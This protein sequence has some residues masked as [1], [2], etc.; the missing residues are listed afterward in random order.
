[1]VASLCLYGTT[2]PYNIDRPSR[3]WS[4]EVFQFDHCCYSIRGR[5]RRTRRLSGST[6]QEYF[7]LCRWPFGSC[8]APGDRLNDQLMTIRI[9]SLMILYARPLAFRRPCY[10]RR[11]TER[12]PVLLRRPPK[13]AG[14]KQQISYGAGM[15]REPESG[16]RNRPDW[17]KRLTSTTHK[18]C[19]S[20]AK[21]ALN[22][23]LTEK[24]YL[25]ASRY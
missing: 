13:V 8:A 7:F 3:H 2:V 14:V 9:Y 10:N 20:S 6:L 1:M 18:P 11:S 19:E 16:W 21:N 17:F 22:F 23:G 24:L 12:S 25:Y 5:P 15:T 4:G